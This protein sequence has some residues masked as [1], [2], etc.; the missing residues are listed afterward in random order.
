MPSLV[1]HPSQ[2]VNVANGSSIND[3]LI[4]NNLA[5]DNLPDATAVV[6]LT[7]NFDT[8]KLVIFKNFGADF[9]GNTVQING[10]TLIVRGCG[11]IST[12]NNT[13]YAPYVLDDVIQ[14]VKTANTPIGTNRARVATDY[15][16]ALN[17]AGDPNP[18]YYHQSFGGDLWGTTITQAE[19]EAS[20]FGVAIA[21]KTDQWSGGLYGS[22]ATIESV[23]LVVDYTILPSTNIDVDP[24]S[25]TISPKTANIIYNTPTE[26]SG[27][28]SEVIDDLETFDFYTLQTLSTSDILTEIE[29]FQYQLPNFSEVIEVTESFNY[30]G[31]Q[32]ATLDETITVTESFGST[33]YTISYKDYLEP[34]ETFDCST[35]VPSQTLDQLLIPTELFNYVVLGNRTHADTITADEGFVGWVE[36]YRPTGYRVDRI[37]F[38]RSSS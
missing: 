5:T 34:S 22:I 26:E 31:L 15:W 29:L 24:V 17:T 13:E 38:P 3:W 27:S 32:F 7:T 9:G 35:T 37:Y 16:P 30:E 14:L 11:Q 23:Y 19:L 28:Y 10:I 33:V 2:A 6:R 36:S 4:S 1:I 25:I 21:V 8:S 18:P 20:S 12:F